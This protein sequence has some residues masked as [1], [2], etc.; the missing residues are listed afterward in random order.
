MDDQPPKANIS[1]SLQAH[2]IWRRKLLPFQRYFRACDILECVASP[3][4]RPLMG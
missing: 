4:P 1:H 3:W 2:K